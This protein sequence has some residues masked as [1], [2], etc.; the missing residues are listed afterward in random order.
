MLCH[1][2]DVIDQI[3]NRALQGDPYLSHLRATVLKH[4]FGGPHREALRQHDL[5]TTTVERADSFFN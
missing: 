2:Y 1:V 3:F 4:F 5:G